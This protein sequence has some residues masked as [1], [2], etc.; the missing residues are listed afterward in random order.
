MLKKSIIS[1]F[2]SLLFICSFSASAR[3]QYGYNGPQIGFGATLPITCV[4]N[5]KNRVLYFKTGTGQGLYYC[6]ATNAWSAV[7]SNNTAASTATN[8]RVNSLTGQ[9]Q[10]ING[11]ATYDAGLARLAAGIL[12]STD[13]AG[14][15]GGIAA[16]FFQGSAADIILK[17]GAGN[18]LLRGTRAAAWTDAIN[19][20]FFQIGT[21]AD[22]VQFTGAS[23]GIHSR[24]AFTS[25]KTQIAAASYASLPVPTENF[26][27]INSG[28]IKV[29]SVSNAGLLYLFDGTIKQV[30]FGAADSAG[31]GFKV[32]R[33]VN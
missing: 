21:N 17:D 31:V 6:A 26:E 30:S 29:F 25:A 3:A 4:T 11:T 9:V 5:A 2:L 15:F 13:S 23:G 28:N 7:G 20:G 14:G 22:Y 19:T 33:V 16:S 32:L 10:F 12:K 8:F 1:V 24:L 18:Q 27:I